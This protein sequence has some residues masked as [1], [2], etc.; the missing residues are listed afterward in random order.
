MLAIKILPELI[1]KNTRI[2]DDDDDDDD[3][4]DKTH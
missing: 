3:D 1:I 4:D 2:N